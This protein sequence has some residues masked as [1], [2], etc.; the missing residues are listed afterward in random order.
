MAGPDNNIPPDN[1]SEPDLSPQDAA[2]CTT[3]QSVWL[4]AISACGIVFGDIGTSPLY[5]MKACFSPDY[6]LELTPLNVLGI[7][8]L[9]FWSLII[10]VSIKYILVLLSVDDDGEGGVFALLSLLRTKAHLTNPFTLKLLTI[11]AILGAALL[12]GDGVITPAISVISAVEGLEI[13]THGLH[14][15]IVIIAVTILFLLFISQRFGIDRI[16]FLFGPLMI[17]WFL[18]IG[19]LGLRQII[20]NPQILIAANPIHAY[21]FFI[22]APITA[23]ILLGVVV[24]CITGGEA[25]YADLGQFNRASISLAWYLLVWP[26]LILN[27]FGQGA[28]LLA[29]P[30]TIKNPFFALAPPTLLYPMISIATIAAII[31]SQA[32]IT[33]AFSITK[34]AIHLDLLPR[35]KTLQT[36]HRIPGRIYL[37]QVNNLMM[38]ISIIIVLAF[39]SSTAL[40]GAYGIAVTAVM[41]LTTI[42]FTV[43]VTVIWK[44]PKA[45]LFPVIAIFLFVDLSFFTANLI[46]FLTGGWLPILIAVIITII[47][48]TW[49]QGREVINKIRISKNEKLDHF[50]KRIAKEQPPRIKGTGVFFTTVPYRIPT[51]LN[52]IYQHIPVLHEKIVIISM[53]PLRQP[54]VERRHQVEIKI[55]GSNLWLVN[56]YFGYMQQPDTWRIL[57]FACRQQIP[58]DLNTV[59]VFL[60][61]EFLLPTGH[62]NLWRWQKTL[63]IWLYRNAHTLREYI[64]IPTEQV[65]EI[66]DQTKI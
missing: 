18:S 16:S 13:T 63:F 38:I 6:G 19:I 23:F 50:S 66:G 47:M 40:T 33:G 29:D 49:W 8:S 46:K 1:G 52:K 20:Q 35:L 11:A 31:A 7:L 10:V 2:F 54:R 28:I 59:T 56:G 36:S 64:N 15:Y 55:M 62:S 27:Y 30:T 57:T 9:V 17:I 22:Y 43:T 39:Q 51:S 44:L 65:I 58:V 37:P 61:A 42:I 21:N 32:I 12:Y 41:V 5:V 53:I 34:Q 60:Y 45:I 24:L 3:K 26:A 48:G 4:L 25:L 14:N